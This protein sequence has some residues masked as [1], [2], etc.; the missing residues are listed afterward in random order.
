M[1]KPA[2]ADV[3]AAS[4]DA[5]RAA[6]RHFAGV[7]EDLHRV[8]RPARATT[9]ESPAASAAAVFRTLS[10]RRF[11]HLSRGRCERY[12]AGIE[13]HLCQALETGQPARFYYD[14]GAGYHASLDPERYALSFQPALG[15]LLLLR[16]IVAFL[17]EARAVYAGAIEF[18]LVIDNRCAQFVNAIPV[19]HTTRY[20]ERLGDII[21]HFGLGGH[22]ALLL[23]SER[24]SYRAYERVFQHQF[25]QQKPPT[26]IS[27]A[28]R[29]NVE[30]FSGR[31]LPPEQVSERLMR[32]GAGGA[33]TD[34]LLATAP[35]GV[36]MTQRAGPAT[37]G[38]RPFHGGDC[39]IQCGEV[40]LC[41]R[42]HA[43]L[44]PQLVTS[45]NRAQYQWDGA[46]VRAWGVPHLRTIPVLR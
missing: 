3:L 24:T 37:F 2:P 42:D 12:R 15:E 21:A 26:E 7:C 39:R 5:L 30:R 40:G 8:P 29:E 33:T 27:T 4:D 31:R 43:S 1:S 16:Q 46:D 23:E 14:V 18:L 41:Q 28:C 11:T 44:R 22:I 19:E 36:R 32:Y 9:T 6:Q 20:A 45:A 13:T 17:R 25:Q 35:A 10:S 34:Q 38:F